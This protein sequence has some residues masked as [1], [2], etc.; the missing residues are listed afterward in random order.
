MFGFLMS[1]F[2][3]N[4]Y[5]AERVLLFIGDSLT[6][7]YGVEKSESYPQLI[8]NKLDQKY[9]AG[10]FKVLNGSVSGSTSASGL[11]RLNWFKKS[12]PEF[13]I[14][15]L[16]ANDGLRGVTPQMTKANLKKIINAAL[17]LK[18]K[19][20]LLGMMMPPNYGPQY[21]D[22]FKSIYPELSKEY[23]IGFVPFVL[24]GVAGE[25][26]LNQGDGIHPNSKGHLVISETVWNSLE[27][28]L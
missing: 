22:E 13:L 16:G 14:L 12:N 1:L 18:I 26:S 28:M 15:G 20:L 21:T 11:S 9:G 25:K 2:I 24:A 7:G 6:E 4:S 8:Q 5:G 23:D 17:E 27:K 19:V 10:K 3:M